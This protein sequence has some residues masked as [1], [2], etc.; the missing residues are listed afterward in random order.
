MKTIF[1]T[2]KEA[3]YPLAISPLLCISPPTSRP[4]QPLIFLFL[5]ISLFWTFHKIESHNMWSLYWLLSLSTMF[6]RFIHVTTCISTSF[7][8]VVRKKY[9]IVWIYSQ[10]LLFLVVTFY[11][12]TMSSELAN[13]TPLL[14]GDIQVRFLQTSG[15]NTFINQSIHNLILWVFLFKD[16]LFNTY[17]WFISMNSRPTTL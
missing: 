3:L 16:A 12:V 9:S 4:K 13:T 11:K 2:Q 15:H 14:L 8:F 7:L 1:N 6:A 17:Y 10:F 5:E